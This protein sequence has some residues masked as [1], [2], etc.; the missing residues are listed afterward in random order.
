MHVPHA[1]WIN[2]PT[3]SVPLGLVKSAI[4]ISLYCS[5][6]SNYLQ[7]CPVCL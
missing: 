3:I 7:E 6:Y 5:I 1:A 2:T 4:T